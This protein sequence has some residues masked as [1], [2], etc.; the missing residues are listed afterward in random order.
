MKIYEGLLILRT[1]E[2]PETRQNHLKDFEQLLKRLEGKVNLK[3]EWGSRPLG[4]PLRKSRDGYFVNFEFEVASANVPEITRVLGLN[5][6]ILKH[7][8]TVKARENKRKI[9]KKAAASKAAATKP[10]VSAPSEKERPHT[11]RTSHSSTEP[12][13]HARKPE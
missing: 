9:E 4:Y 5:E 3:E 8:I 1:D 13:K 7:M 11:T 6:H 10:A 2:S 12:I